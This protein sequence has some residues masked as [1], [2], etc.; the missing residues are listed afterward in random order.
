MSIST[1]SQEEKFYD[2]AVALCDEINSILVLCQRQG[3]NSMDPIVTEIAITFLAKI[4]KLDLLEKFIGSS[5]KLWS[6]IKKRDEDYMMNNAMSIFYS[7]QDHV[8][9]FKHIF[10]LRD[11]KGQFIISNQ[12]KQTLWEYF[13]SFVRISLKH[14]ERSRK[15]NPNYFH[16]INLAEAMKLWFEPKEGFVS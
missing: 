12:R 13:D 9:P 10:S 2:N 15:I 8:D 1:K 11:S 6:Q 7:F 14:I 5:Y 4:D 3:H 16:E